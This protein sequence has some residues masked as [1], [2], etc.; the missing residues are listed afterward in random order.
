VNTQST[1]LALVA[2]LLALSLAAAMGVASVTSLTITRHRLV[3]L[4][5]A[6]AL[7]AA[8]SF[9]SAGVSREGSESNVFLIDEAVRGSAS[10]FLVTHP[11][12]AIDEVSLVRAGNA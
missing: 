6:T 4:A 8:D 1:I 9:I 10:H 11:A 5:D 7:H 2:R 3:A 12:L